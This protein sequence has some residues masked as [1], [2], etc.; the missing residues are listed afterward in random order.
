[1]KPKALVEAALFVADRPLSL[2]RLA[3]VLGL[4][5]EAVGRLLQ[6]LAEELSAPD[7][8]LE[9]VQEGGGYVLRVKPELA[10]T[11][12]PL[13]PGQDIAEPVLRTLAVIAYQGPILQSEVVRLRGQRAYSHIRELIERGFVQAVEEGQTK[14]LSVTK[15]LLSYFNVKSE[16]ELRALLEPRQATD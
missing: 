12:R 7:R 9:L 14:R 4:S 11:V 8:G 5:E 13:A 3:Q 1:M 15:D 2:R 16:E 10:E 6:V